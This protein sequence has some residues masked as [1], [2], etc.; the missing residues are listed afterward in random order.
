[1]LD[2][3]MISTPDPNPLPTATPAPTAAATS[4]ASPSPSPS[5]SASPS[6]SHA[7]TATATASAAEAS[8]PIAF[9][10]NARSGG[11]R[12]GSAFEPHRHRIEALAAGGPIVLV[13]E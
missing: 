9:V 3:P 1:M 7:P 10:L 5:P 6:A 12:D 8:G 11:G 2:R 4:T 13:N